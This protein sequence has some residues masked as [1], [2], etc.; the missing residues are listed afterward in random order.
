[1]APENAPVLADILRSTLHLVNFYGEADTR[2]PEL[3]E[4]TAALERAISLIEAKGP[5]GRYFP[6]REANGAPQMKE[7]A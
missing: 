1:M 3:D 6:A 2:E 5:N 7:S 4:L